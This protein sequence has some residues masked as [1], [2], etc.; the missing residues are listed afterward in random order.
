MYNKDA[1]SGFIDIV[2]TFDNASLES[3]KP[4]AINKSRTINCTMDTHHDSYTKNGTE[5]ST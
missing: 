2:G 5:C 4:A 1:V 3:I